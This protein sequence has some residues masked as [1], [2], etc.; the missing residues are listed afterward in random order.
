MAPSTSRAAVLC[1]LLLCCVQT[2]AGAQ[3]APRPLPQDLAFSGVASAAA[4][5][6]APAAAFGAL[7]DWIGEQVGTGQPGASEAVRFV[8]ETA[9]GSVGS[10]VGGY[11][12]AFAAAAT[13]DTSCSRGGWFCTG[14]FVVFAGLGVGSTVGSGFMA[15]LGNN[16]F[17]GR[18]S[19]RG[20]L[21]GGLAGMAV[22]GAIAGW[23]LSDPDVDD[24]PAVLVYT[25]TQGALAAAG[26]RLFQRDR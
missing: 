9:F 20:S 1:F 14:T 18:S 11:I 12:G 17:G 7:G 25:V 23:M 22:G 4:P 21:I 8:G 6:I 10:L 15:R 16:V 5:G 26:G 19:L 2:R 3:L 24:G 13:F